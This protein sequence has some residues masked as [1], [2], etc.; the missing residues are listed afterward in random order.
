[1]I[2]NRQ[3]IINYNTHLGVDDQLGDGLQE[4]LLYVGDAEGGQAGLLESLQAAHHGEDVGGVG[5]V[6][7]VLAD[8]PG[9]DP[10]VQ[11][12]GLQLGGEDG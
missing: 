2:R 9:V 12:E 5:G 11:L 6:D 4:V 7:V 10:P 1:M 8:T 3:M